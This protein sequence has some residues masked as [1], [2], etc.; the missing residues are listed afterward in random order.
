MNPPPLYWAKVRSDRQDIDLWC[1][2]WSDRSLEDA[3][4][5]GRERCD[6]TLA[7]WDKTRSLDDYPYDVSRPLREKTLEQWDRKDGS[8][9]ALVTINSYGCRVLNSADAMFVDVDL[10]CLDSYRSFNGLGVNSGCLGWLFVSKKETMEAEFK[11]LMAE[12]EASALARLQALVTRVPEIGARAYRTRAGLR[13]LMTHA[14]VDPLDENSSRMMEELDAD[15]CYIKLCRA[16]ESFRAR[17][18]PKPWRCGLPRFPHRYPWNPQQEREVDDWLATY[19]ATARGFATCQLAGHY[20][21]PEIHPELT[22]TIAFHDKAT[23]A[24]SGLSLA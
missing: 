7:R 22:R 23:R 14:P 2:G 8:I 15:P 9:Q 4:Q 21:N 1:W 12:K 18:T 20:G 17:L 24:E 19:E 3:R 5:K 16:Q 13:Y 10:P 11:A 6:R